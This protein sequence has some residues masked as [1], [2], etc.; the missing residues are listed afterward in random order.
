MLESLLVCPLV[1]C[2]VVLSFLSSAGVSRSSVCVTVVFFFVG[3]W[4]AGLI[5]LSFGRVVVG[6]GWS[7]CRF[8]VLSQNINSFRFA[9]MLYRTNPSTTCII[10]ATLTHMTLFK[11]D[12][13]VGK[14]RATHNIFYF[15]L[16]PPTHT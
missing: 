10:I 6:G 14:V 11:F 16:L 8:G 12:I 2:A 1:W 15:F 5:V 9:I 4:V 7:F 3:G 13:H